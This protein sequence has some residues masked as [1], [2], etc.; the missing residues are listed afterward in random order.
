MHQKGLLGMG[1]GL[2]EDWWGAGLSEGLQCCLCC[3]LIPAPQARAMGQRTLGMSW[4]MYSP[5]HVC[6]EMSSFCP[7]RCRPGEVAG[8]QEKRMFRSFTESSTPLG[9]SGLS[10]EEGG[11]LVGDGDTGERF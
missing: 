1:Q 4:Q 3:T 6:S 9:A 5:S 2:E 10:G 8:R 11:D 7:A